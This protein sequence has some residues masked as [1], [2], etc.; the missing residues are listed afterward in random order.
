MTMRPV[1]YQAFPGT[2][3]TSESSIETTKTNAIASRYLF[4]FAL[5]VSMCQIVDTNHHMKWGKSDVPYHNFVYKLVDLL[6]WYYHARFA[7][8]G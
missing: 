4:S 5:S 7:S 2:A 1:N 3:S 6:C 8:C